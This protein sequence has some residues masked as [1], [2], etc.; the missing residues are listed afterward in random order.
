M[1]TWLRRLRGALGLALA[2]AFTWFSAGMLLL[3]VVG[4]DAADVPFPLGFGF[5]GFWA[6]LGFSGFL[7]LL[8]RKRSFTELSLARVGVWGALG[9]LLLGLVMTAIVGPEAFIV[10]ASVFA[11]A[12]ALCAAGTLALARMAEEPAG[13]GPGSPGGHLPE[14]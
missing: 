11:G 3:L 2:W 5:L 7:A 9:G 6:G 14:K 10:L 13:V 12:G 1:S 4:P 8:D